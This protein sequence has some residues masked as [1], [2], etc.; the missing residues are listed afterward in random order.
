MTRRPGVGGNEEPGAPA[1]PAARRGIDPRQKQIMVMVLLDWMSF[2]MSILVFPL[3]LLNEVFPGQEALTS[4][5]NGLIG[6]LQVLLMFL[7]GPLWGTWSDARGRK[8]FLVLCC[9]SSAIYYGLNTLAFTAFGQHADGAALASAALLN[10]TLIASGNGTVLATTDSIQSLSFS[11]DAMG[12]AFFLVLG[13]A[14]VKGMFFMSQTFENAAVVDVSLPAE[15]GAGLALNGAMMG[16]GL[17]TGSLISYRFGALLNH[18]F[19]FLFA[20][21]CSVVMLVGMVFFRETL[22]R[23]D[24]KP[25]KWSESNPFTSL[26]WLMS[27]PLAWIPVSMY[28]MVN[29]IGSAFMASWILWSREK[30]GLDTMHQS[31]C[32]FDAGLASILTQTLGLYFLM[33][34]IG[35]RAIIIS[36][37]ILK[38]IV[39]MGMIITPAGVWIVN[40]AGERVMHNHPYTHIALHILSGLFGVTLVSVPLIQA[41]ISHRVRASEQGRLLAATES[42][43]LTSEAVGQFGTTALWT[44]C[45]Y[46]VPKSSFWYTQDAHLW[47]GFFCAVACLAISLYG[48]FRHEEALFGHLNRSGEQFTE[49]IEMEEKKPF[50]KHTKP[51]SAMSFFKTLVK[52][53]TYKETLRIE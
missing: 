35:E 34:L 38:G 19:P 18:A 28:W 1:A 8:P 39:C 42:S 4:Y 11:W 25:F 30:F 41:L 33:P 43:R 53:S 9:A 32:I 27:T 37:V 40:A 23:E 6:G 31:L 2:V 44:Y 48:F 12:T 3:L 7:L 15:R 14:V 10:R 51:K 49:E 45:C 29:L 36:A 5:T 17:I 13:A 47:F 26:A 22:R 24:R 52:P 50:K 21:V 16:I 20:T 46:Q